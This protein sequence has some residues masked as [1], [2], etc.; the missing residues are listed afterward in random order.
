MCRNHLVSTM[1]HQTAQQ[2]NDGGTD[3][4]KERWLAL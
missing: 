4:D 3:R 1:Q 2:E